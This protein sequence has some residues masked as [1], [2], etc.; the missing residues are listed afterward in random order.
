M[1]T[2]SPI[3]R[4]LRADA[5]RNR[6]KV[7]AAA[8][9]AF[10]EL[11]LDAQM[12]D[13]ARRAGVGVGTLYRHFPTK[14]ALVRALIEAKMERMA[15]RG[16]EA[17]D[18]GV[19]EGQAWHVLDTFLR[20]CA[21]D[22]VEDRGLAQVTSTQPAA[23]FAD[24]ARA[25]GLARIVTEL[26]AAAQREGSVRADATMIDVPLIMCG[27]GGIIQSFGDQAARRFLALS[28]DGL[29][30]VDA[31]PLPAGPPLPTARDDQD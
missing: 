31:P 24:A 12:D 17:L 2:D 25:T 30:N 18:A 11:G 13:V 23:S 15:A 4:P 27:L 28:L 9:D 21:E 8:R 29:R 3:A 19:P 16:R 26:I 22:H 6:E 5:R 14:D 1:A 10:A 7:V 20:A